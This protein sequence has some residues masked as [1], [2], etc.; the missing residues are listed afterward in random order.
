M[1]PNYAPFHGL[2]FEGND[3]YARIQVRLFGRL[4]FRIHLL[5]LA[6]EAPKIVYTHDLKTGDHGFSQG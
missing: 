4:A 1:G 5:H 2:C 6:L 3:P